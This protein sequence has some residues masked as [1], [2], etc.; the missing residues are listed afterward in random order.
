MRIGRRATMTMLALGALALG[1][2]AALAHHG[3]SGYLDDDFELTGV[4]ETVELGQPHGHLEVSADDGVWDVVLGPAHRNR[5]AGLTDGAVE[6]GDTVTAFG[7]RHRDPERREMKTERLVVG[8]KTYDIY[9]D[10]L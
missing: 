3:W 2:T 4:V 8:D 9:P 10:R 1:T 5:R 6:A 7:K